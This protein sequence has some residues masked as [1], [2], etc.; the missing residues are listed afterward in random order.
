MYLQDLT[1]IDDGNKDWMDEEKTMV[2]FGKRMLLADII[3]LVRRLQ[4]EPYRL[5]PQPDC[6]EALL[7]IGGFL[8]E[9]E[10]T[11]YAISKFIEEKSG[12]LTSDD[13]SVFPNPQVLQPLTS[14][15]RTGSGDSGGPSLAHP[16]AEFLDELMETTSRRSIGSHSPP[17]GSL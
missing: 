10:K 7:S 11:A 2:N 14:R 9:H 3:A 17:S 1:F 16:S 13:I 8:E 12:V 15:K 4:N 5:Q 6:V